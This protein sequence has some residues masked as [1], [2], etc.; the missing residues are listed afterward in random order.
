MRE[1]MAQKA[2]KLRAATAARASRRHAG[3][4][5]PF[6]LS[7]DNGAQRVRLSK[8]EGHSGTEQVKRDDLGWAIFRQINRIFLS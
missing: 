7:C 4:Q 3:P 6:F 1:S 5:L 2:S 8:N